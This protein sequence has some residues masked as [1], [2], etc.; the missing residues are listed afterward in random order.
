[1][2]RAFKAD[3]YL[4]LAET[5]AGFK[6]EPRH[7]RAAYLRRAT[8]TAY[9]ALFHEL[10]QHGAKRAGRKGP[11]EHKQ[12]IG[13]WYA[14]GNFKKTARWVQDIGAGRTTPNPVRLLMVD[15]GNQAVPTDLEVLSDAFGEL[16][17]A[18]HGAD[19]DPAFAATRLST[20]AHINTARSGI[21]AI[22]RMDKAN[23]HQFDMFLLLALGGDRMIKN[24]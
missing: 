14:H 3:D 5:L 12:A 2:R 13:R 20:L 7:P 15:P 23:L 6:A 8:S 4:H 9:Y 16:Q 19:Y 18:R 1:M 21:D 11:S 22:K 17:E 10:V 24:S